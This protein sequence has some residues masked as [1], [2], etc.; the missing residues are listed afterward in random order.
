MT[1]ELCYHTFNYGFGKGGEGMIIDRTL[2]EKK[3]DTSLK[4]FVVLSKAYRTIMEQVEADIQRRGLNLTDFAV[5]EL[6]YHKGG[7]PLKN[8][9][10]KIL[11]TS[12]SITYVVNKLEKKSYLK[13]IPNPDDRRV[14]FAE[15]TE[16]GAD[17]LQ[18][19]FPGHW[20]RI[21]EI[22]NGL[23][24]AEKEIAI[25]LLKKLGTSIRTL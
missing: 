18:T 22:T 23:N 24:V 6:L 12:G 1:K 19:I 11:L 10:E 2:K 17:L 16:K 25:E 21:E 14:T 20:E 7:Q 9:G 5:L 13:R 8:I 15:I 4:L 3:E